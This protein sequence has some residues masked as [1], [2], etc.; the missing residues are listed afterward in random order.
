MRLK[1]LTAAVIALLLGFIFPSFV[2]AQSSAARYGDDAIRLAPLFISLF[3]NLTG[4][5][6]VVGA[7]IYARDKK[8]DS[9]RNIACVIAA[10]GGIWLSLTWFGV[11]LLSLIGC[12]VLAVISAIVCA[13]I[14][15]S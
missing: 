2:A 12:V 14:A 13:A 9:S 3:T 11:S 7:G 4:L 15:E 5:A 1:F 8:T 10:I 6:V